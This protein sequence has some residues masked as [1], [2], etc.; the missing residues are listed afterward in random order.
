[1]LVFLNNAYERV[2]ALAR[3]WFDNYRPSLW[4]ATA[5][6]TGTATPV[7]DANFHELIPLWVS[8]QYA[9]TYIPSIAP[10][11]LNEIFIKEKL[12]EE[13]FGSRRY[14]VVTVTI[15]SPGVFTLLN[16]GLKTDDVVS[17]VTSGALPTGLSVDTLYYVLSDG[18]DDDNFR[19]SATRG[20]D[21]GTAIN[22]SGTQSGTHWLF[23]KKTPRLIPG[24]IQ[25]GDSSK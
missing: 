11:L 4:D 1:M 22:T 10:A 18:L 16:H 21:G 12:L 9:L 23:V 25:R 20:K 19:I 2:S 6:T 8:Y 13:W 15:A 5:L 24:Y 17:L 7:L 3:R 14:V